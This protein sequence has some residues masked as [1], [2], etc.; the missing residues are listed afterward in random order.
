MH[1]LE[2]GIK[3]IDSGINLNTSR[4]TEEVEAKLTYMSTVVYLS[5]LAIPFSSIELLYQA[6]GI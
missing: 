1:T 3:K 2:N 5:C 6:L 4:Y